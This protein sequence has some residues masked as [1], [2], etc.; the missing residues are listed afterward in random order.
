M[1]KKK[2]KEISPLCNAVKD[3]RL[4]CG[5]TQERFARRIGVAIMTIS[6]FETG[7]A[8]PRDPRVLM[9]LATVAEDKANFAFHVEEDN[10]KHNTL[11][12]AE[13]QFRDVLRDYERLRQ[14]EQRLGPLERLGPMEFDSK[15]TVRSP[16]EWRLSCAARLAALY[17]PEQAAAMEKAAGAAIAI[18][19]D[20]LS[21]ADEKQIDYQRFERE[22]FT[23]AEQRAFSELKQGRDK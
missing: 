17:F 6:K 21:R 11:R 3:L 10:A 12:A 9:T 16:R 23:L 18:V 22:I 4:A 19:D 8:E 5:D 7:R 15:P 2:P 14:A 13:L 20:V 1:T